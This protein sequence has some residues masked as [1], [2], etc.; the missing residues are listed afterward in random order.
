MLAA[1]GV[2]LTE[3][4]TTR[5]LV[6]AGLGVALVAMIAVAAYGS[7]AWVSA[8]ATIAS[9][10]RF[11][12]IAGFLLVL[13]ALGGRLTAK[14]TAWWLIAAGLIVGL[15]PSV[16]VAAHASS[17]W[18]SAG[19]WD[20]R[21]SPTLA[22]WFRDHQVQ[23]ASDG[24]LSWFGPLGALFVLATGPLSAWF[25]VRGVLRRP[26][27]VAGFAPLLAFAIVSLTIV[28]LPYQGRYFMSSVAL[29]AA[30]WVRS[31]AG[32]RC[33]TA[34][35][36]SRSSR[37]RSVSQIPSA[38]RRDSSSSA[39]T[40]GPGSGGCRAGT[41]RDPPADGAGAGRDKHLALRGGQRAAGRGNRDRTRREQLWPPVL[42]TPPDPPCGRRGRGDTISTTITWL[43][44]SPGKAPLA[45]RRHG[46]HA[47]SVRSVRA[48]GSEPA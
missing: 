42:R 41:A 20:A 3:K 35:L 19:A 2:R 24:A 31:P 7:S 5:W 30:T 26:A 32:G 46:C 22:E 28:Y 8:Q 16:V 39:A 6:G 13:A 48:S 21:G 27:L 10:R 36:P 44:T 47:A 34:S 14:P 29:A 23:T 15:L 17:A 40:L 4:P 43:V 1:L 11:Y 38:S 25:V 18:V 9:D 45:V 12:A 33:G 37:A